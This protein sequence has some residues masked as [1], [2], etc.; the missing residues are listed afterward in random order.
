MATA[1]TRTGFKNLIC[2]ECREAGPNITIDLNTLAVCTCDGC[3]ESFTPQEARDR[4][5]AELAKW[6]AVCHWVEAAPVTD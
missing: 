6:D 3:G 1:K 2:P 5:A 4:M